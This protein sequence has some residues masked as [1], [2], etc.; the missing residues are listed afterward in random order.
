[1]PT[2]KNGKLEGT[3]PRVAADVMYPG[4]EMFNVG[5]ADSEIALWHGGI[6]ACVFNIIY[7]AFLL[8]FLTTLIR[9]RSYF[10]FFVTM[11]FIKVPTFGIW[12]TFDG[13]IRDFPRYLLLYLVFYLVIHYLKINK[14]IV[15]K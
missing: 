12:G 8:L 11:L 4:T 13:C 3:P 10:A 14:I 2:S 7:A 5:V 15:E 1:V 6:V 9:S